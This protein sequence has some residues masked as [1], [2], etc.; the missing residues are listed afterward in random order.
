[1]REEVRD[2]LVAEIRS[3]LLY[4]VTTVRDVPARVKQLSNYSYEQLFACVLHC[5]IRTNVAMAV[6]H[7]FLQYMVII[8]LV[9]KIYYMRSIIQKTLFITLTC[10]Y[11]F[12]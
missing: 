11:C 6:G 4:P 9:R 3:I 10:I 12:W 2:V 7:L 5:H 8:T 1:M